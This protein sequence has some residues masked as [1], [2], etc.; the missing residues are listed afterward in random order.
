MKRLS[1]L[2]A[3]VSTA[4]L[5]I[6]SYLGIT[7]ALGGGYVGF[8]QVSPTWFIQNGYDA[9]AVGQQTEFLL[10]VRLIMAIAFLIAGLRMMPKN[11][12]GA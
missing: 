9:Q 7:E 1:E 8:L 5:G 12:G 11:V 3:I 4:L 6:G 10:T 2:K